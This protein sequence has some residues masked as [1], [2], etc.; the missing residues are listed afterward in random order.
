[1]MI[2]VWCVYW[3]PKDYRNKF[4]A[5]LFENDRPTNET[6]VSKVYA[7]IKITLV[8]MERFENDDPRIKEVWL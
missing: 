7:P 5:R 4:V 6:L 3:S 8:R 1:M 2:Q